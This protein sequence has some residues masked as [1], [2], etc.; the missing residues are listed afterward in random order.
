MKWLEIIEVR[1]AG[2][3]RER[4]D[5]VLKDLTAKSGEP[6]EK[7]EI[8]IYSHVS[9]DTDYSVHLIHRSAKVLIQG[10]VLGLRVAEALKEFGLVNYNVWVETHQ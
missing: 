5:L 2:R 1:V 7:L 3:Q 8:R 9:I 10:S 4:L 6:G